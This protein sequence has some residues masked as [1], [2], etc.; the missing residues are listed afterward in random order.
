MPGDSN[1]DRVVNAID[2]ALVLQLTA[3]LLE[4]LPCPA[5]G[6]ANDDGAVDAIDS[7]LILQYGAGLLDTLPP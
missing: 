4:H 6:D 7:A 5:N 3:A 2:A 1:C